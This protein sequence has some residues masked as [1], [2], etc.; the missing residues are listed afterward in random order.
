MK[1]NP[2]LY[3][4]DV[5]G[6]IN[7]Q[8]QEDIIAGDDEPYYRYKRRILLRLLHQIDFKNKKVLEVGCGPGG[9][10]TEIF[11]QKPSFLQGADISDNMIEMAKQRVVGLPIEIVKTNGTDLPFS[12]NSFDIAMTVTVLQHVTDDVSACALILSLCR[13]ASADVYIFERVEKKK[14][15]AVSNTGRTIQ[16]YTTY[17]CNGGYNLYESR[18]LHLKISYLVCGA[19]RKIFNTRKRKEGEKQS[20][21]AVFLQKLLL[22]VTSLLDKLLRCNTDLAMLHFK[23]SNRSSI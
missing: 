12:D 6:R 23:K 19:I 16:E 17:F 11:N 1:Y 20:S 13:V 5:A 3:W 8:Q 4:D 2:E 14:K 9:N 15:T 10:L 22:P 18:F 7:K 21:A